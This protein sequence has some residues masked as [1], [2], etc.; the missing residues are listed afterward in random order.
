MRR[1]R[2]GGGAVLTAALVLTMGAAVAEPQ[3]LQ[4]P[5]EN[6]LAPLA[7]ELAGRVTPDAEEQTWLAQGHTVRI[8]VA[9]VPPYHFIERNQAQGIAVDYTRLLCRTHRLSCRFVTGI[10]WVDALETLGQAN[11]ADLL[12][13]IYPSAE[14][15]TRVAFTH[16]YL[17]APW[18]IFTR[19][20][21]P[22]VTQIADLDARRVAVE[23]GFAI[24]DRLRHDWPGLRL[25]ESNTT[26][27]ALERLVTAQVDAYIGNLVTGIYLISSRGFDN[28][29]IAAPTPLGYHEQAM[30]VRPDW[31]PLASLIDRTLDAMSEAEHGAIRQRWLAR[32]DA[33]LINWHMF[34]WIIA[35]ISTLAIGLLGSALLWNRRLRREIGE[36][37]RAEAALRESETRYRA[38]FEAADDLIFVH[39]LFSPQTPARF[40]EVNE[41]ICACLGYSRSELLQR[42][43]LDLLAPED[44]VEVPGEAETLLRERRLVFEKRLLTRSGARIPL[45]FHACLFELG[46]QTLVL[47]IAR[48]IRERQRAEAALRDSHARFQSLFDHMNEGVALHELCFDTAGEAVNYILRGV[49]PAYETILGLPAAAV[50]NQTG[51]VAY[52]TAEPPYLS[53]YARVALTGEAER[54]ETYFPPLEKWFAIS[55]APWGARGFATLFT[56]ITARQQQQ[57]QLEQLAHYDALTGLPNRVLLADRLDMALAQTER[58]QQLLA[59]CYLDLDG[60]KAVN[61]RLGHEVGDQVLVEVARRLQETLR[62]ADTVARLGGDEFVLLITGLDTVEDCAPAL[63]RLLRVLAQPYAL[64]HER[65][66]L[67]ASIGVALYPLDQGDPDS[68]L[69]HADQAMYTAKQ[70]GRNVYRL[71]DADQ[72]QRTRSH[73][74]ALAEIREALER[75]EFRLYY[76]PKVDM[77]HGTVIGAEALIRWQH[78]QRGLL[79]PSVFLPLI[80]DHDLCCALGNWVLAEALRQMVEWQQQGLVLPVSVNIAAWH[81]QQAGFVE[82]LRELLAAVPQ[83]ARGAL[84]LEVLETATLADIEL[85]GRV[86]RECRQLGVPVALDDFGTGYSSLTYF[87]RLPVDILKIDQSFVRDMLD[88]PEDLAIIAGVIGLTEAFQRQVIAEGVEKAEQGLLLMHLGCDLAQGYG[89]ARPMPAVAIPDW[90]RHFCPEPLWAT[91]GPPRVWRRQLSD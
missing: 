39:P 66:N 78:P 90:T 76:Q 84:S 79:P 14:R 28:L 10:P 72:D 36:R 63:E 69:R 37:Q 20:K 31:R 42:S 61:D 89:I 35:G 55:V 75:G 13:T 56:D 6:W 86:L 11:G 25:E 74:E 1:R 53:L 21:G 41:K 15:R 68:L 43:P 7:A 29:R 85:A 16:V 70:S 47:S 87:K 77:R 71:F 27:Q 5:D 62:G 73:R 17:R 19:E 24:S 91:A 38:L 59:V 3:I 82:R 52:A 81:L 54:F 65:I 58:D 57:R 2:A 18:V 4:L 26:G 23:K 32:P 30:G 40:I 8:R 50:L 12:L 48:D 22:I 88:D 49:N 44:L 51:D 46:G 80:D 60:F 45:E 83:L 9:D 67:S 33:R 34:W 64:G